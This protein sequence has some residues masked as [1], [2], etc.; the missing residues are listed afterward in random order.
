MAQP[1][2]T[3]RGDG[4][5]NADSARVVAALERDRVNRLALAGKPRRPTVNRL[6]YSK[7]EVAESLGVSVDFVEDHVWPDLRV[8]RKGRRTFAPVAELETWLDRNAERILG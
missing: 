6:A 7:A 8:V 2:E 4:D 5:V 1:T 3:A